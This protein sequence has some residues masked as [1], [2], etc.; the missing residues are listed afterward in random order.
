[1]LVTNLSLVD[2]IVAD[3]GRRHGMSATEV[4]DFSGAVRLRLVDDNYAILRSFQGRSSLATFLAAVVARLLLDYQNHHWGKWH[5]SA[6]A[7]RLGAAAV[8]LERSI[9]REGRPPVEA[10]D[11]VLT[12]YQDLTRNEVERMLARLPV[13]APRREHVSLDEAL[14]ISVPDVFAPERTSVASEVSK[15]VTRTL[16]RLSDEDQLIVKLRF[17]CEM[18]VAQIS[19]ALNQDSQFLYRRLH[20]LFEELRKELLVGGIRPEDVNSLI[21]SDDVQLD[22]GLNGLR[23][24]LAT[25]ADADLSG[26]NRIAR[27]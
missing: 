14:N 17:D 3:I 6:E 15:I 26:G 9:H 12:K 18:T 20:K 8:D 19:R 24:L 23:E 16:A 10:I 1:M 13:R 25:A 22:F 21:G 7:K 27:R 2:R 4:E 5:D 11:A